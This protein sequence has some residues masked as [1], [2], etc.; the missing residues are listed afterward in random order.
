M[1]D[2]TFEV[3]EVVQLKSGGSA[4]T[5][6]VVDGDHA[7][8]IWSEGKKIHR[9]RIPFIALIKFK[10]AAIGVSTIRRS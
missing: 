2:V 9:L 1:S 6:E 8:C 10:R 3:G 4:M 5:V 7:H